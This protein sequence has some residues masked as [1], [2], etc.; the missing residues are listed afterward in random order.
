MRILLIQSLAYSRFHLKCFL[1][2][3]IVTPVVEPKCL[4]YELAADGMSCYKLK[5]DKV[6]YNQAKDAC[7]K[8]NAEIATIGGE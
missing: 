4:G 3:V 8:D 2:Y 7:K 6:T 1:L 5:K